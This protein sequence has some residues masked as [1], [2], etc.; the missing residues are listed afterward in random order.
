M[1]TDRRDHAFQNSLL[2]FHLCAQR[3]DAVHDRRRVIVQ[4]LPGSIAV[5][6]EASADDLFVRIVGSAIG[7]SPAAEPLKDRFVGTWFEMDDS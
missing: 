4:N 3:I 2:D 5:N 7:Q 6:F 1:S